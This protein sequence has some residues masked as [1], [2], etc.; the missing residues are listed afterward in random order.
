MEAIFKEKYDVKRLGAEFYE[1]RCFPWDFPVKNRL[2]LRN[3][4]EKN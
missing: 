4:N 1:K 3:F 2:K